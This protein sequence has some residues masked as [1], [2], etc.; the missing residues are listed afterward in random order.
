L[1]AINEELES[2]VAQRTTQLQTA[3]DRWDLVTQATQDG[4]YDWDLTTRLIVCSPQWKAMHGF[5]QQAKKSHLS[6]GR[7]GSIRTTATVGPSL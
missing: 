3:L 5:S 4:V 1:L 2:R 7:N 6:S